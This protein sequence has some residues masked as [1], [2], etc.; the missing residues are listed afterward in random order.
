MQ[1][2]TR[3]FALAALAVA[4]LLG[5]CGTTTGDV[6]VKYTHN[7]E[8]VP[9]TEAPRDG[10]YGLYSTSDLQPQVKYPL[11]KGDR[12]GFVRRNTRIFAVAG[13]HEVPIQTTGIVRSFVWKRERDQ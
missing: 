12:L 3:F 2:T 10:L 6:L 8:P 13:D 9:P 11:D 4:G 7:T 1:I 5:G